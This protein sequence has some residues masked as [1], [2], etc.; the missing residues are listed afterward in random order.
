MSGFTLYEV[1][2]HYEITN[3]YLHYH[4]LIELDWEPI[5]EATE[6]VARATLAHQYLGQL[7]EKLRE[8]IFGNVGTIIAFK[9]GAED[10]LYLEKEF[11]PEFIREDRINQDKYHIYL[12]MAINGKTSKPFSAKTLPTFYELAT[13]KIDKSGLLNI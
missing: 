1:D 8:A 3:H 11:L 10:A 6:F 13:P 2:N 7:D 9:V 12:K 5:E 4:P